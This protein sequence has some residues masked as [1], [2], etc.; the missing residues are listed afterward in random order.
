MALQV[1]PKEAEQSGGVEPAVQDPA[2][3]TTVATSSSSNSSS[4]VTGLQR[5]K[6]LVSQLSSGT[7]AQSADAG[8]N[9]KELHGEAGGGGA[10]L[11]GEAHTLLKHCLLLPL[12]SP[13]VQCS[14]LWPVL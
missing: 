8:S 3:T 9:C 2:T 7:H 5:I 4:E 12:R 11:R 1:A 14:K 10:R 13:G 6:Q